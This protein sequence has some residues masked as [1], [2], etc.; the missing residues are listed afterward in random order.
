[1]TVTPRFTLLN[2]RPAHQAELLSGLVLQM[3]GQTLNCPTLKIQ[4]PSHAELLLNLA[5]DLQQYDKVIL[6]SANAV[7]GLL[8][9]FLNSHFNE[10]SQAALSKPQFFAIGKATQQAGLD[11]HL[12]V[13]SLAQGRYDSE[14]LLQH[15]LMQSVQGE[16]ILI[17]KGQAGRTLLVESLT[18]SG[19]RVDSWD[20]YQRVPVKFCQQNWQ[21]F[22][23]SKYPILL[24]TSVESFET[25]M[26]GLLKFDQSYALMPGMPQASNQAWSFLKN[27]IVFSERIKQTMAL[28][29]WQ[30]AISVVE[31][32]SDLGIIQA[33][34][35]CMSASQ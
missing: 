12:P 5:Q 8:K 20:V 7:Q 26:A 31:Q 2:T 27:T 35:G 1:M 6:T 22:I 17:V 29:G 18:A 30:A 21:V 3:G 23:K 32:Q 15:P 13:V 19:A 11:N 4:W 10:V 24:F 28:Q 16:S 25:F 33:I 14:A 34:E 9:A